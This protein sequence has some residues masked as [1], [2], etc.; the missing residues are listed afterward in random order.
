MPI[1]LCLDCNR[2]SYGWSKGIPCS[3]CGSSHV[4]STIAAG[5]PSERTD[6]APAHYLVYLNARQWKE[7]NV[8]ADRAGQSVR[9]LLATRE[10]ADVFSI[11]DEPTSDGKLVVYTRRQD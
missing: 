10:H 3:Y 5:A 6:S 2:V 11:C 4:A 8:E 9:T 7:L 1:W